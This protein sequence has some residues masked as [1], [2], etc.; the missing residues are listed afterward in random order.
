MKESRPLEIVGEYKE[1]NSGIFFAPF[2]ITDLDPFENSI[3]P[4]TKYRLRGNGISVSRRGFHRQFSTK[5]IW[6]SWRGVKDARG[7]DVDGDS[8]CG[9]ASERVVNRWKFR[10]NIVW[11]PWERFPALH[12]R[13]DKNPRFNFPEDAFDFHHRDRGIDRG[14]VRAHA[15]VYLI[16]VTRPMH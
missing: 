1:K 14:R 16:R 4:I 3:P 5:L 2:Q 9:A 10:I 15:R 6:I 13:I 11:K 12:E 8:T 7:E